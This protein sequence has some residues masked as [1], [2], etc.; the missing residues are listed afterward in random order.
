[1]VQMVNFQKVLFY[2]TYS[3]FFAKIRH[4]TGVR[5]VFRVMNGCPVLPIVLRVSADT[6]DVIND[7]KHGL[8]P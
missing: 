3:T 2:S 1:M 7:S 6:V 8:R 5:A 4:E